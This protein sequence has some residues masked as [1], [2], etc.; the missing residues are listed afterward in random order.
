MRLSQPPSTAS[1]D[2]VIKLASSEVRKAIAFA[3]SSG[4]PNRPIGTA[5][6]LCSYASS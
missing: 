5:S 2:P 4:S 3:N 6:V 1:V